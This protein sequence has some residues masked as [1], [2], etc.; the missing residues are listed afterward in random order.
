MALTR[1]KK[2]EVASKLSEIMKNS[3][4]VA[5]VR[6]KGLN[7]EEANNVRKSLREAG[8]NYFVAKKTLIQRA[9]DEVQFTGECPALEGEI[10][11]AY[12]DDLIAPARE[13]YQFQKKDADVLSIVGGVFDGK[14]M[15]QEEMV[16]VAT[17]PSRQVLYGQF[18]NLINSPLQ[19]F[20]V[21]L[22]QIA[23]QKETA[24]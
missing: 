10:A 12:G 2:E 19:R 8:V 15:T 5:F 13:I 14:F 11:L 18:A 22:D 7:V 24:A 6:F 9:L 16:N 21:A 4:S 1:E 23:Q 17:I 3:Q 20:A